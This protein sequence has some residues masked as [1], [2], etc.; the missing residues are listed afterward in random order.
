MINFHNLQ[1]IPSDT[2]TY[3]LRPRPIYLPTT[4]KH[5]RGL[6]Q[7]HENMHDYNA[8]WKKR[9]HTL[10]SFPKHKS[11]LRFWV[12]VCFIT[13]HL[14]FLPRLA[15]FA[16]FITEH[17]HLPELIITTLMHALFTTPFLTPL[18]L[19]TLH[20]AHTTIANCSKGG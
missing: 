19:F 8:I 18:T 7:A 15:N 17:R 2:I 16:L 3:N 6:S 14:K 9:Q 11:S 10:Y 1:C 12:K 13:T 5:E 20:H 4:P